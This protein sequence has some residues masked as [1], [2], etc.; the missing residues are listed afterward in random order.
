MALVGRVVDEKYGLRGVIGE[1]GMGAVY[2]AEHLVLGRTVALKVLNPQNAARPEAVSRFRH[3]AR[4]AGS[5]GHPNICEIYDVGNLEDGTPY[6]VMERLVGDSLADRINKEGALPFL[7]VIDIVSQVL[8]GLVAAHRKGV[9]H[10]DIKPENVF[11]SRRPGRE[12]IV[13]LLDFG[14]SKAGSIDSDLHLTRTGMVM[15]TPYY[16]A[17]EQARGE[18]LD[19]RVDLYATGVVLYEC[20]TGRRPFSAPNYNALLVQ[21]LTGSPRPIFELRPA[22]PVGFAPIVERAMAKQADER[23]QTATDFL[24]TLMALRIELVRAERQAAMRG[25]VV[26]RT[27]PRSEPPARPPSELDIPVHFATQPPPPQA[28]ATLPPEAAKT[29]APAAGPTLPAGPPSHMPP[30]ISADE[31]RFE[32]AF[33]DKTQVKPPSFILPPPPPGVLLPPSRPLPPVPHAP[34]LSIR[35]VPLPPPAPEQTIQ[36]RPLGSDEAD[37]IVRAAKLKAH[38]LSTSPRPA[39]RRVSVPIPLDSQPTV[40]GAPRPPLMPEVTAREVPAINSERPPPSKPKPPLS[41]PTD[42]GFDEDEP[43]SLYQPKAPKRLWAYGVRL[44]FRHNDSK[45]TKRNWGF[46]TDLANYKNNFCFA[47]LCLCVFVLN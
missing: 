12:T 6:L 24:D 45:N 37:E 9:I 4:V 7:D 10:R 35:T 31:A 18:A 2:E 34:E 23:F 46:R 1:G 38:A 14:I 30:P 13:K 39:L 40:V 20:L 25:P 27:A 26:E 11:L 21:I 17:P 33:S 47:S 29:Q 16:M 19:H 44:I 15:G 8:S 41:L 5:I 36:A 42:G 32:D 3:E 43:T 28:A 22:I